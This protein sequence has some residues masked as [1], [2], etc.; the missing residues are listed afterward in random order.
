MRINTTP[1]AGNL[2]T[3]ALLEP[4]SVTIRID[5]CY[6]DHAVVS[7]ELWTNIPTAGFTSEWHATAG[8]PLQS[9]ENIKVAMIPVSTGMG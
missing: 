2:T 5:D 1:G 9:L 6:D 8:T 3:V 7:G 4:I